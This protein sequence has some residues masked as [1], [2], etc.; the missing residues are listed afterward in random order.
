MEQI[1]HIFKALAMVGLLVVGV[2]GILVTLEVINLADVTEP[3]FK[4]TA[5]LGIVGLMAV[6]VYVLQSK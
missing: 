4:T 3:I 2:L 5:V 1:K 6:G